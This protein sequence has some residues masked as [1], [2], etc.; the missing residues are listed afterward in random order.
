VAS[1][2]PVLS[3][4]DFITLTVFI[5]G[6]A[7]SCFAVLRYL[8][9]RIDQAKTDL[10]HEFNDRY[11]SQQASLDY[12][13]NNMVGR[14]E[15]NR[16]VDRLTDLVDKIRQDNKEAVLRIEDSQRKALE[17]I[18][19]RITIFMGNLAMSSKHDSKG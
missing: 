8:I 19:K 5:V 16:E 6:M 18:D 9:G 11:K 2:D 13:K 12:L 3:V 10:R 15:V 17:S 4:S 7:G 1:G 14:D